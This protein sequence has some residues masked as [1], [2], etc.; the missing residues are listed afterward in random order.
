MPSKLE[1]VKQLN[2]IMN[3]QCIYHSGSCQ[4]IL[5]DTSKDGGDVG[6]N[7]SE[8]CDVILLRSSVGYN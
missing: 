4:R 8:R 2:I 6:L 1:Q 3:V 7:A 5:L